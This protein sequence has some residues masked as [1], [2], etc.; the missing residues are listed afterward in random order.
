MT[1]AAPVGPPPGVRAVDPPAEGATRLVLVRHG[2]AVCNV[3]G[4]VGGPRGCT[5]LTD[6]GVAQAGA[7]ADRLARTGELGAVGALYASV[8]PRATQTAAI[9][10][11]ALE[12]WREG[13]ALEVRRDCG[14]CELH[15]GDEADGLGWGEFVARFGEP[16][17]DLDPDRPLAPGGES[18]RGFVA[19]VADALGTVTARHRGQ[20]VV[21]VCHA[22]VVEAALGVYLPFGA[23]PDRRSWVRTDHAAMTQ[24]EQGERG[25]LLVRHND[26]TPRPGGQQA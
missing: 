24:L 20:T 16:G 4:V 19:R 22:G 9:V 7:L 25:W 21:V 11:P 14:L 17:W 18:W 23:G 12:R 13:A 15:P 26:A 3:A 8:L 10:A 5:G 2:E 1:G 6:R